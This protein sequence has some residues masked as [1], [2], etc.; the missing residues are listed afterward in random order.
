MPTAVADVCTLT[1]YCQLQDVHPKTQG[2]AVIARL[3]VGAL[4]AHHA[5]KGS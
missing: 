1:Y 4:P 2:Y 5:P 3:I